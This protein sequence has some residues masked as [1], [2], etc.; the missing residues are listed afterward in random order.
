MLTV[1][2]EGMPIY[3]EQTTRKAINHN[4]LKK[5]NLY[6]KFNIKFPDSLTEDQRKR[7]E[8][9]LLKDEWLINYK[10]YFILLII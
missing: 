6:V 4:N 5:G 3:E 7:I 2:N 10:Y 8:K 1:E 9:V